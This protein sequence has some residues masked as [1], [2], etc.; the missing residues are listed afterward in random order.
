MED[1]AVFWCGYRRFLN[2]DEMWKQECWG[3]SNMWDELEPLF[4]EPLRSSTGLPWSLHVPGYLEIHAVTPVATNLLLCS[5]FTRHHWTTKL[6]LIIY[7]SVSIRS[8]ACNLQ[9]WLSRQLVNTSRL[10]CFTEWDCTCFMAKIRGWFSIHEK[11]QQQ[12]VSRTVLG[13]EPYWEQLRKEM[14][15]IYYLH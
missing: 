11:M 5:L 6:W 12:K 4:L 2:G 3:K 15:W 14:V 13:V 8:A 7:N 9:I 10:I 1:V